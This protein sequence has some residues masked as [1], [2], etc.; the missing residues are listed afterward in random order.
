M[1]RSWVLPGRRTA[2][3]V[4]P[5]GELWLGRGADV[6]VDLLTVVDEHDQEDAQRAV[7]G[8]DVGVL[9]DVDLT[10]LIWPVSRVARRSRTG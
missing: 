8:G 10:S 6:A 2:P 9:V 7:T 3:W 4:D 1:S 5:A